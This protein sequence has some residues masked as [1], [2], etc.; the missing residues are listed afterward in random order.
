MALRIEFCANWYNY[1]IDTR[2]GWW[3]GDD[4]IK[5]VLL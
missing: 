3:R 5:R 1:I 4:T 2:R